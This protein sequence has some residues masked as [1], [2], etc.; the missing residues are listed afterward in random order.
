MSS[1]TGRRIGPADE[2]KIGR[3]ALRV[4]DLKYPERFAS[5]LRE[6]LD[7][8]N[9]VLTSYLGSADFDFGPTLKPYLA[10]GQVLFDA[11]YDEAMRHA[12]LLTPMMAAYLMKTKA[13]AQAE[14]GWL[15]RS[16]IATI[17][18]ALRH[19]WIPV[20]GV[21]AF[22]GLTYILVTHLSTGFFPAQDDSQTRISV[23]LPPGSTIAET[24]AIARRAGEAAL[25][26]EHVTG[27]FQA[28]GSASTG[29]GP[30]RLSG[31]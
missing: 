27:V 3:R 23:T 30:I 21:I 2:D 22:L 18:G 19:R 1:T 29:G 31:G 13:H 15:M 6:L 17:K 8:H 26:V 20:M 16:Y 12:R 5:K 24:D 14:D 7:L 25:G 10:N 9:H 4:Q 28:T 11:V